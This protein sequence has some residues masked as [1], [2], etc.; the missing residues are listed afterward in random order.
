MI[1]LRAGAGNDLINAG[2]G[3]DALVISY[4]QLDGAT[5]TVTDFNSTEDRLLLEEL[6]QVEQISPSQLHL[7]TTGT[8]GE[9]ER[10]LTVV[11][12]GLDS[13]PTIERFSFV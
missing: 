11:F 7:F 9:E 4:D 2:T 5:D 8:S 13:M 3:A 12:D 10:E 6:I 1:G